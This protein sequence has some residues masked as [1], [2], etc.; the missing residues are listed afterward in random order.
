MSLTWLPATILVLVIGLVVVA[1][2]AVQGSWWAEENPA[3]SSDQKA[4]DGSSMLTDAGF[5]Y[6]NVEGI[7]RVRI[8]EGALPADQLGM[9]ADV[10]KSAQFRRPVRAVIAGRDDVYVIDDTAALTATTQD[11]E[12]ASVA[13]TLD[14]PGTWFDALAHVRA[15]APT[16]GWNEEQ[17]TALDEELARFNRDGT[18]DAFTATV[19]PSDGG[20]QVTAQLL[21]HRDGG[22][23]L[24]TLVFEPGR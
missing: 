15:L 12:L 21:F 17:V 14:S 23:T 2:F 5:D 10:E 20:A 3:A 4:P 1:T 6:A 13:V 7:V 8:G 22:T 19:G 11:G 16:V 18:E 9:G 24:V